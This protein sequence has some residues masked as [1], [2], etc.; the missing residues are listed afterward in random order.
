MIVCLHFKRVRLLLH[1]YLVPGLCVSA[2]AF[3]GCA[4]PAT[5]A[6]SSPAMDSATKEPM[7]TVSM[8]P[9][10]QVGDVTAVYVTVTN[11][12]PDLY[13]ENEVIA[14]QA[15]AVA[16]SGGEVNRLDVDHAIEKAGAAD[17]LLAALGDRSFEVALPPNEALDASTGRCCVPAPELSGAVKAAGVVIGVPLLIMLAPLLRGDK[18]MEAVFADDKEKIEDKEFPVGRYNTRDMNTLDNFI[19][20]QRS[21]KGYLFFP[22]GSYSTLEI[23]AAAIVPPE[24]RCGWLGCPSLS[25]FDAVS[26]QILRGES[27]TLRQPETIPCPWRQQ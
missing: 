2:I 15:H 5:T 23:T 3:G 7:A 19:E 25:A 13:Q 9:S 4:L 22:R 10:T 6:P 24:T 8:E 16:Q 12:R 14:L 20:P 18:I 27:L 17:K 11:L 1:R 26:Q 21:W